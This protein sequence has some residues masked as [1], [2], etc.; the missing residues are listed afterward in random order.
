MSDALLHSKLY[1]CDIDSLAEI[2][3]AFSACSHQVYLSTIF[4][5]SEVGGAENNSH[6]VY[7]GSMILATK[8]TTRNDQWWKTHSFK[9][10]LWAMQAVCQLSKWRNAFKLVQDG[11]VFNK[12][13]LKNI[14]GFKPNAEVVKTSRR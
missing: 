4:P 1:R 8:R 13:F 10:M 11:G 5:V 9:L 2:D 6:R 12:D 14:N 7:I 3:I